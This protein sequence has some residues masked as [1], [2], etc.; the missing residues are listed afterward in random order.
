MTP[1]PPDFRFHAVKIY[2]FNTQQ[3]LGT[4]RN[5][6]LSFAYSK[7][8]LAF[9]IITRLPF[10]VSIKGIYTTREQD[11]QTCYLFCFCDVALD[12]LTFTYELDLVF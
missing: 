6:F 11:T 8:I 4:F 12:P 2:S 7:L 3:C 9:I 1:W 10:K 5:L